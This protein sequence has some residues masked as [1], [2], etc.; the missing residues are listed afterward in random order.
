M[1][2]KHRIVVT[3]GALAAVAL[4][5]G[6]ASAQG[7]YLKGFG[8]WTIPQDDNFQLNDKTNDVSGSSGFDFDTG[9]ALGA[10]VGYEYS[11]TLAIEGEYVY[12]NADA[13]FRDVA[14]DDK[15]TT[16]SNAWMV[17]ALYK[18]Q[19]L[20]A[21]GAFHPYAGAGIGIADQKV[22]DVGQ[23]LDADY[24]FAWQ[25]IGG[26]SYDVSPQFQIFGET[27]YFTINDQTVENSDFSFK[28]GYDTVDVL[29]GASYHF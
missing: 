23:T 19:P 16:E 22:K 8:G 13:R 9:Y 3:G 4:M 14:G 10:A 21:T 7:Y 29:F 24:D 25:L 5:A 11:P 27:R 20:G 28:S 6:A 17:N 12:R 26:V 18:F 15:G 2:I 1:S